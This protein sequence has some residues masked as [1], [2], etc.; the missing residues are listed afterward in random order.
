MLIEVTRHIDASEP[1]ANGMYD[2]YYEYDR[3]R[4]S[5]AS[6]A[7]IARSYTDEPHDAHFLRAEIGSEARMLAAP[8]LATGLFQCAVAHLHSLGKVNLTWLSAE[9]KRYVGI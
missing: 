5:D 9:A 1:D 2:Y 7:L 4:F 8:D 3:F 6:L